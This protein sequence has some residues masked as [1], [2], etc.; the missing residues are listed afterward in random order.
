[1]IYVEEGFKRLFCLL[2]ALA[3]IISTPVLL[4]ER[5]W[6]TEPRPW[7]IRLGHWWGFVLILLYSVFGRDEEDDEYWSNFGPG[8]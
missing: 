4:F 1:M 8:D 7:T 5:I 6:R 2:M 3:V